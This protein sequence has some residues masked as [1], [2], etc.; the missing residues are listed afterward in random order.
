MACDDTGHFFQR[1]FLDDHPRDRHVGL[2]RVTLIRERY[3][4]TL[5]DIQNLIHFIQLEIK[6]K[7]KRGNDFVTTV[8]PPL[9]LRMLCY[10]SGPLCMKKMFHC[11][12][13]TLHRKQM[14]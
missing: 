9:T 7:D 8:W 11:Q 6:L 2:A 13:L 3:T 5:D 10:A 1:D 14:K 4:V 12:T